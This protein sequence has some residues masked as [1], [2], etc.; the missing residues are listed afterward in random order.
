MIA[1]ADHQELP[2]GAKIFSTAML[3][4]LANVERELVVS[5]CRNGQIP[6][7]QR[8]GVH[9]I[10]SRRGAEF[11]IEWAGKR[12]EYGAAWAVCMRE[13][14]LLLDKACKK[15]QP[16]AGR[17]PLKPEQVREIRRDFRACMQDGTGLEPVARK[18]QL[19]KSSVS[20][21]GR[22]LRHSNVR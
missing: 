12:S 19:D 2:P 13:A 3:A 8:R 4:K 21:I 16:K 11:L 9:W 22:R 5:M 17:L 6:F 15:R 1:K 10:V 20:M 14:A 7:A 18:H